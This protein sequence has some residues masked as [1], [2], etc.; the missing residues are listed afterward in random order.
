MSEIVSIVKSATSF[1]TKADI[2]Y[3]ASG[4]FRYC[5]CYILMNRRSYGAFIQSS[6][7]H[8]PLGL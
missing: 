2:R 3:E 5:I 4:L 7:A 1:L 6:T 8:Q